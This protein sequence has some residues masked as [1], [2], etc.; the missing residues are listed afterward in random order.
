[1]IP[2]KHY[3]LLKNKDELEELKNAFI[4]ESIQSQVKAQEEE[5]ILKENINNALKEE[6]KNSKEIIDN[7]Y[8]LI[9]DSRTLKDES[10]LEKM[11]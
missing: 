4:Q 5:R 9:L 1:M 2:K 10:L 8:K 11:D 6:Y 3:Y 7:V